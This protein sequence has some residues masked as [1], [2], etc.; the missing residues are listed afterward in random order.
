M[1]KSWLYHLDCFTVSLLGLYTHNSHIHI[2]PVLY[3]FWGLVNSKQAKSIWVGLLIVRLNPEGINYIIIC[4]NQVFTGISVFLQIVYFLFY[5]SPVMR[6]ISYKLSD[7][8][9]DAHKPGGSL[10]RL[11]IVDELSFSFSWAKFSFVTSHKTFPQF[12]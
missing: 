8:H 10:H 11:Y 4:S 2:T 6:L 5:P 3:S 1:L 12:L 9:L 7:L